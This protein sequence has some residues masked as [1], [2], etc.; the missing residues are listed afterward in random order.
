MPN[1]V[2]TQSPIINFN[3]RKCC[4]FLFFYVFTCFRFCRVFPPYHILC[5]PVD[6]RRYQQTHSAPPMLLIHCGEIL[7]D[8]LAAL[9]SNLWP[10]ST[11]MPDVWFCHSFLPDH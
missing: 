2:I 5:I 3:A 7:P 6:T 10:S 11:R 9:A 1:A 4:L 8:S